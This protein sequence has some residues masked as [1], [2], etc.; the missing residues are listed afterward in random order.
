MSESTGMVTDAFLAECEAAAN[1]ANAR[2][3]KATKG[4]W[5]ANDGEVLPSSDAWDHILKTGPMFADGRA[6]AEFA[7]HART[8]NPDLAA[9]VLTLVK[10]VREQRSTIEKETLFDL[11]ERLGDHCH[12]DAPNDYAHL[13]ADAIRLRIFKFISELEEHK[14]GGLR[15]DIAKLEALGP[16]LETNRLAQLQWADE[17]QTRGDVNHAERR[18][19]FEARAG[20]FKQAGYELSARAGKDLRGEPKPKA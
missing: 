9:R 4:P 2:A 1:E 13:D 19:E 8:S 12:V 15:E 11:L 7:A 3:E 10:M 14:I 6:N 16:W 5:T 20:A 17:A 18:V